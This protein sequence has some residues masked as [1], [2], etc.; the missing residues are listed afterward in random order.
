MW[1]NP[2]A[3]VGCNGK[4]AVLAPFPPDLGHCQ[5]NCSTWVPCRRPAALSAQLGPERGNNAPPSLLV[6]ICD[7]DWET[8]ATP[9]FNPR[10]SEELL[11]LS[12]RSWEGDLGSWGPKE[13]RK[14]MG[15][16]GAGAWGEASAPHEWFE[17]RG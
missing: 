9:V 16:E 7:K 11:P 6:Y 8:G 13:G 4:L 17:R 5:L 2:K 15:T 1:K 14:Q 12:G 3:W 10:D